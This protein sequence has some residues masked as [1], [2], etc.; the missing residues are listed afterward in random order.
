LPWEGFHMKNIKKGAILLIFSAFMQ[1]SAN[2]AEVN[3]DVKAELSDAEIQARDA[4][5]AQIKRDIADL[6]QIA[7]TEEAQEGRFFNEV[8]MFL[9]EAYVNRF[10]PKET[11]DELT[12]LLADKVKAIKQSNETSVFTAAMLDINNERRLAGIPPISMAITPSPASMQ[13]MELQSKL[14]DAREERRKFIDDF[15]LTDADEA[16]QYVNVRI[17]GLQKQL[18]DLGVEPAADGKEAKAVGQVEGKGIVP[19]V[20]EQKVP[21]ARGVLIREII[22]KKALFGDEANA[23]G[24][25]NDLTEQELI[26]LRDRLNLTVGLEDEDLDA[27]IARIITGEGSADLKQLLAQ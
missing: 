20:V 4:K 12:T 11:Y 14:F 1:D 7:P 19:A 8:F 15:G 26:R 5:I 2:A 10:F 23:T 24:L 21:E 13:I 18:Q 6:K 22:N 9:N 27:A 25:L 17:Q 3:V 16:V